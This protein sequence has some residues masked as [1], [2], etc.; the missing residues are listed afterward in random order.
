M[1]LTLLPY[2][3]EISVSNS[4]DITWITE[5][6]NWTNISEFGGINGFE[7]AFNFR[8]WERNHIANDY[9]DFMVIDS[10]NYFRVLKTSNRHLEYS[11]YVENTLAIQFTQ[12][13]NAD[14]SYGFLAI[15]IDNDNETCA[16]SYIKSRNDFVGG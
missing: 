9:Y 3:N 13:F 1:S 2:L 5:N 16:I 14:Q 10:S 12:S 7:P 8:Y 15:A 4:P 11:L 6:K